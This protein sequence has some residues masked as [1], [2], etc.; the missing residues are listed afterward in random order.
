MN[1][2]NTGL[3]TAETHGYGTIDLGLGG[4]YSNSYGSDSCLTIDICP[5]LLFAALAAAAAALFVFI[6]MQITLKG[7]RRKRSFHFEENEYF[8]INPFYIEDVY[9]GMCYYVFEWHDS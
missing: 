3:S 4:S 8:H 1:Y 5:D 9:Y 6:Y 2:E 7:R